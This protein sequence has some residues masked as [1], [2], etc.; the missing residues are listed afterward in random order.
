MIRNIIGAI[1]AV[2]IAGAA[3]ATATPAKAGYTWQGAV[4]NSTYRYAWGTFA[5]FRNNADPNAYVDFSTY[6]S[7]AGNFYATLNGVNVSC[8]VPSGN[9]ALVAAFNQ[10][11]QD[12][13]WFYVSWDASGNCNSI[14]VSNSSEYGS[15]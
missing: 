2:G 1:A 9:A 10:V 6:V 8:A 11:L 3:L 7:P 5:G 15:Y 14:S 12:R 13:D 4:V